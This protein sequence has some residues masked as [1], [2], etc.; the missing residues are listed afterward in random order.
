MPFELSPDE[1]RAPLRS[2]TITVPGKDR[3]ALV[4]KLPAFADTNHFLIRVSRDPARPGDVFVQMYRT[5][6]KMIGRLPTGE[7]R[8]DLTVYRTLHRIPPEAIDQGVG[9]LRKVV[10]ELPGAR[11]E[12]T[13]FVQ[14]DDMTLEPRTGIAPVRSAIIRLPDAAREALKGQLVSF[15]EANGLAVGFRQV[16]PDPKQITVTMHSEDVEI[17]GGMPFSMNELHMNLYRSGDRSASRA[18][19]DHL[20]AELQHA[21]LKVDGVTFSERASSR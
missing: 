1:M 9:G 14:G 12:Q 16:T 20:F 4:G 19:I 6:I 2:I 15:S 18:L 13:V 5:D 17:S 10:S 8:L 11:F 21:V 3:D 7:P